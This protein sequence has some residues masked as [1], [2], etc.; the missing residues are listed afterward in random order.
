MRPP[1]AT[2]RRCG[3]SS[4]PT[5]DGVLDAADDDW[6]LFKVMVTNADGTTTLKTLAQLDI[7]SIGLITNEQEVQLADGSKIEGTASFTRSDSSTGKV[8]D[9]RLAFDASGDVVTRSETVNGDGSTTIVSTATRA[10]G[11]LAN[12]TSSTT[13]ADGLS[14]TIEF[15]D[16]G[17]GVLDRVQ[18]DVTVVNG[19]GSTTRTVRDYDGSGTILARDR[20]RRLRPSWTRSAA[21]RSRL[22]CVLVHAA[23]VRDRR[24][25]RTVGS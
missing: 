3:T 24:S 8:A 21:P 5:N 20:N 6:S 14:I 22:P 18:T 16:D 4:T 1:G 9:A 15:D 17:D 2:W 19:D 7:V 11:S 10:N 12:T 13:S 23:F 25:C